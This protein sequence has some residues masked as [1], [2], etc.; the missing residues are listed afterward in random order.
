MRNVHYPKALEKQRKHT[1]LPTPLKLSEFSR[2][3][4]FTPTFRGVAMC[5][6]LDPVFLRPGK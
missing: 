2:K 3:L 5:S 6:H 4:Q 1:G